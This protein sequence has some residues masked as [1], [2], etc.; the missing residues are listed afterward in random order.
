MALPFQ[1]GAN[2]WLRGLAETLVL[3]WSLLT[4]ISECRLGPLMP[5]LWRQLVGSA[6][7]PRGP[8]FVLCTSVGRRERSPA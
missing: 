5:V 1:D 3:V 7:P 2:T 4:I 6:L 8:V